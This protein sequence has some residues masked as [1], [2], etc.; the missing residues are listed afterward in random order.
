MYTIILPD[1]TVKVVRTK[2][3]VYAA[4]KQLAYDYGTYTK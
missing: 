1:G 2:A 3:Q 4:A